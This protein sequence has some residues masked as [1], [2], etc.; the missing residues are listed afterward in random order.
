MADRYVKRWVIPS[1]S[2][3]REYIIALDKDGNYACSC[4]AWT[5][6]FPRRNCKHITMVL[7]GFGKTEAEAIM[8]KLKGGR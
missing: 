5:R 1:E 8:E 3:D 4:P 2:S 7:D 6:H